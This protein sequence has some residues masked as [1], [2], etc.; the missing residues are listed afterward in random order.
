M[1]FNAPVAIISAFLLS[2]I[3]PDVFRHRLV[4]IAVINAK[5][6][7]YYISSLC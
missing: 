3:T 6:V 7:S 5:T 2:Y 1:Y 4:P